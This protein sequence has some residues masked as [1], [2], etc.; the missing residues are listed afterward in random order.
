MQRRHFVAGSLATGASLLGSSIAFA[1]NDTATPSATSEETTALAVESGYA[2]V[3]GLQLYYEIHGS[4]EPLILLHGAFGTIG[5]WG[6]IL[7][8][9]A[10]HHQ[11]IAVELQGHGHTADIDRPFSYEQFAD[12]V[13]ALMEYLE[14]AQADI[15]GYSLGAD[16]ALQLAMRHPARVRKLV[17]ISGNYRHDGYYPEVWDV[18]AAMTPDMLTGTPFADAYAAVAPNPDGFPALV[19]KVK[20][21]D[22]VAF[23]WPDEEIAAIAAPTL[24]VIGDSD[25]VRPEHAV[26]L[27][28]LLGGGVPG[29]LT[30]LPKSQLAILPG[31]THI[32]IAFERTELMLAMIA[33]FLAAPPPDAA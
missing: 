2:P 7:E 8:G 10:Q 23:A 1:Q 11:V 6:S 17:V 28:R 30:G 25:N 20:A 13:D 29:D 15:V 16:T 33:A 5:L 19:E 14:I 9:L 12:D 27:F 22:A 18:V 31:I 3:N 32:S 4:G 26:A 24:I 21:F